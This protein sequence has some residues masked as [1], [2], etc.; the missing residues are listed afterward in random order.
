MALLTD[1]DRETVRAMLA[2]IE[3]PVTLVF[4]TQAIGCESCDAAKQVLDELTSLSEKIV[5]EEVN[6]VLDKEKVATYA[7]DRVPAI[8][9]VAGAD[10][11]IRFYG[12]P[13]GYEFMSLLDAI[14]LASSGEPH[15]SE[16]S[17]ALVKSVDTPTSL[18]VF[19]TPT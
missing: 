6:Y 8:A 12:A 19:V 4:F 9:V 11:R 1:K 7:V 14:L 10:S 16:A 3:N 17:I 15:L 18:Q 5:V 13:T 2:P